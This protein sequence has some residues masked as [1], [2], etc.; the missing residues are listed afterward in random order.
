M[1]VC[2]HT[3]ARRRSAFVTAALFAGALLGTLTPARAEASFPG[4]EGKI[5]YQGTFSGDIY[6]ADPTGGNDVPLITGSAFETEPA[7]SPNGAKLAFVREIPGS[8][9]E[10]F[11]ANAN[12]SNQ[13]QITTN[14]WPDF[15]PAWSADGSQIVYASTAT[16][17]NTDIWKVDATS[18][19]V[20]V[21]LTTHA[22]A[23][24][25]PAWSPDNTKIAY[26]TDQYASGA[27]EI[28]KMNING[29][30]IARLT[31]NGVPDVGPN[32]ASDGKTIYYTS[33]LGSSSDIWRMNNDGTSKVNL[34]T[35]SL[36]G[37]QSNVAASPATPG[38]F[39]YVQDDT[40]GIYRYCCGSFIVNG[41][42]AETAPD[43]QPKVSDHA[44][45]KAASPVRL[46]LV[47]A[48][49]YCSS[50]NTA[51]STLQQSGAASPSCNPAR[52]ESSYLTVGTPGANNNPANSIGSLRMASF[53]NGGAVGEAPPCN[54]TAG[55]QEDGSIKVSY[56][57]VR[58]LQATSGGCTD[59]YGDYL[60]DLGLIAN[61]RVSD[62]NSGGAGGA[63]VQDFA[64]NVDVPCSQTPEGIGSDCNVTTSIDSLLGANGIVE[65]QRAIWDFQAVNVYDGGND[66]VGATQVGNQLFARMGLFFP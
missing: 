63:T 40:E 31:T 27:P 6:T 57:D 23:D 30:G 54:T 33:N 21:R 46:A 48:Y 59:V 8:D 10:I 47:P 19:A 38:S 17:G 24:S 20:P 4:A 16:S 62:L 2:G 11:V 36:S 5:A 14:T 53:C 60:G 37:G 41:A 61:V 9:L 66:G 44:R 56:T 50:P 22:A 26:Q 55:D 28:A 45:P 13:V 7:W 35:S 65:L 32:W 12:G 43:W 64:L 58:C 52:Q 42:D 39:I 3:M 51:H 18:G 1:M 15:N 25:A 49:T 29:S 34:T